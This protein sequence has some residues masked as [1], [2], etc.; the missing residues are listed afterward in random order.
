MAFKKILRGRVM[1][2][3]FNKLLYF[4]KKSFIFV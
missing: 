1:V 4:F 3:F 2:N